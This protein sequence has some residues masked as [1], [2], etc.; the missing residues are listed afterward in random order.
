MTA[1]NLTLNQLPVLWTKHQTHVRLVVTVLLAIYLI[2]YAAELTWKLFSSDET[3]TPQAQVTT[4]N[5]PV[6]QNGSQVDINQLRALNLFGTKSAAP[7]VEQ[8]VTEAPK[9]RLN[10]TL[11][12]VVSS[13]VPEAGAAIIEN[14]GAQNTYG[15]GEKIDGTNA[16][17]SEVFVDRVI[18]KNGAR[19]ETLMLDGVDYTKQPSTTQ[20]SAPAQNV[21][22]TPR[23]GA[24]AKQRNTLSDA[25]LE[26]TRNL[27]DKPAN[28]SDFIA[29]SPYR[30]DGQLMGYR[31]SPGKD[32]TL[33]KSAG[34]K[35]GDI[36]TEINGLDLTD[37]Q[38]SMEAMTALREAQTLQMTVNRAGEII[39]LYLDIPT[40][41][42]T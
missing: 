40:P 26:S 18:I 6:S 7:V 41:E 20:R 24:A 25:A 3:S 35:S 39:T 4:S 11:S 31:V 1:G 21:A 5:A 38:Q 13:D 2:A 29:I 9:T 32:A 27:R 30:R 28:F 42:N 12:G 16:V 37:M 14:K 10:L 17:L 19:R 15:I 36:V 34:L 33:F 22:A 23:S 8:R